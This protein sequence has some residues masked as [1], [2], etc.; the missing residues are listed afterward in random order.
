MVSGYYG[1]LAAQILRNWV[2]T[3]SFLASTAILIA[4]GVL[5]LLVSSEK[6]SELTHEL[7]IVGSHSSIPIAVKRLPLVSNFLMAFFNFSMCLRF[8]NF[9][10]L[11]ISGVHDDTSETARL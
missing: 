6:V 9:V 4:V 5:G 7:N 11:A 3:A 1:L 10:G 8:Y 2:M